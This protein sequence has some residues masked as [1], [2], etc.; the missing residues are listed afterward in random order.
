METVELPILLHPL[1]ASTLAPRVDLLFY[2]LLIFSTLLMAFLLAMVITYVVRYRRGSNADRSGTPHRHWLL[3]AGWT[4]VAAV[5]ALAI[6]AWG[7]KL[8]LDRDRPPAGAM[9]IAGFGKQWM[10][11]FEHANG[12]REINE[13]HVPT[14]RPVVVT[15][16]AE[17]VIH[18]MFVPA[19]RLKMDAVP[20]RTT[21]L[22]FEATKQGTYDLFCA[23]YCG[24][25]HSEMRGYVY[26]M[27][28]EDFA[29]WLAAAPSEQSLAEQ[30]HALFRALGCSGCHDPGGTVRAPSLEGVYG[31][32]VALANRQT[33]LADDAYLRDSILQPLKEVAAGYEPV[34]PSF[35]GLVDEDELGKLI[36]YIKSL[37]TEEQP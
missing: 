14:G 31:H 29:G 18:S 2:A 20:G 9:E 3:E 28:P 22:W 21:R 5:V 34:M 30:G 24:A 4:T 12:R 23:E 35:D 8:Y 16:A 27:A 37:A 36:A 32:P 11:K 13:L 1:E 10:W 17:D 33:R 15:L 19:F 7:A 6:F 26:V 25:E